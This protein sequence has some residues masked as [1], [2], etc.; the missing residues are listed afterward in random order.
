M[1]GVGNRASGYRLAILGEYSGTA[2]KLS[3]KVA[4]KHWVT[5]EKQ[6]G[7]GRRQMIDIG[8]GRW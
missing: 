2:G 7:P 8:L 1:F 3:N 5:N 6:G 4:D